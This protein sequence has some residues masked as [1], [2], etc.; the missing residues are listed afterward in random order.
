MEQ[1]CCWEQ[2]CAW[3]WFEKYVFQKWFLTFEIKERL[4]FLAFH[5][6]LCYPNFHVLQ[7]HNL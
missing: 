7:K 5:L 3:Q 4:K 6:D 2:R 1:M